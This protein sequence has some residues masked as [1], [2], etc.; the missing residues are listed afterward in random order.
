MRRLLTLIHSLMLIG[1][2]NCV[3]AFSEAH[4]LGHHWEDPAYIGEVRIQIVIMA[5][6]A[7]IIGTTSFIR[8]M[9]K[10]RSAGK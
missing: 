9:L 6:I 4:E 3:W 10:N 2:C 8:L 5:A 1:L 7:C